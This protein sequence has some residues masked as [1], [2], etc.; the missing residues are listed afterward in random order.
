MLGGSGV[1]AIAFAYDVCSGS[2]P[3]KVNFNHKSF[4]QHLA[5]CLDL[6]H[7][8][9]VCEQRNT[10]VKHTQTVVPAAYLKKEVIRWLSVMCKAWYHQHCMDIRSDVFL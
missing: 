5:T 3:C 4:R 7:F 10:G 1:L 9:V 6:S 2:N 8:P